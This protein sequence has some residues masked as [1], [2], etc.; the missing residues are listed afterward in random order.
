M[1]IKTSA[2]LLAAASAVAGS[3]A[4]AAPAQAASGFDRCP[5]GYACFFSGTNGTGTIAY[6]KQGSQ[7]LR[8]QGIDNN[9][10]S[11]VNKSGRDVCGYDGYNY[12]GQSL[13][14]WPGNIS[15]PTGMTDYTATRLS[16]VRVGC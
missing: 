7:D 6:F 15:T 14:G 1:K 8:L 3:V 9:V 5:A 11:A 4:L 10:W 13:F 16:S 2:V 12:T